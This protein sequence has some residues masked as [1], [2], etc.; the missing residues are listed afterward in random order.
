[1]TAHQ[2]ERLVDALALVVLKLAVGVCV[3][4]AGFTHVSDDDYART[5]IAQQFAHAPR[6]DPSGTSWLPVPFYVEGLAMMAFGATLEVA[7]ATAIALGAASVVAPYVA[8]RTVGLPRAASLA[9]TAVAMTM[10][11]NV[12]LGV[13][14][15]PEAWVGAIVAG[16]L[17]VLSLERVRPWAAAGLLVGA[18]SRYETWPACA[19]LAGLAAWSAL[20][21]P[22]RRRDTAVALL[23]LAGPVAWMLWNAHAHGSPFHFVTR[24]TTFRQ[25]IGAAAI[26]LTEKI[27]GYPRALVIDMPI[28]AV[29]SLAC[30]AGVR[31][32]TWRR[33]W[34]WP[35]VATAVTI[36]FLVWGDVRDG[37]PTHHAAR[38]LVALG[39]VLVAAGVDALLVTR[40]TPVPRR[41]TI[42]L[43]AAAIVAVAITAVSRRAPPGTTEAENRTVQLARGRDM[44]ARHVAAATIVPCSFEHFAL[45]AAWGEPERATVLPRTGA[46][47]SAECPVVREP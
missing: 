19:L 28:A 10:P 31:A 22:A 44:R 30:L 43:P 17:I 35:L 11:W 46:P 38:A 3:L 47:P 25:S 36:V 21:G 37:A 5:V 20:R 8:M 4:Q 29:A 15:V 39:W 16:A 32:P 9:A 6:W 27:L 23:A 13:A 34:S 42:A 7:R 2:A 18:L 33:R 26:P 24:V 1:V 40:G 14:V 45:L 41:A 12:W